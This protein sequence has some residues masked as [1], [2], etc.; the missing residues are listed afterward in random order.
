MSLIRTLERAMRPLKNRVMLMISR[1]VIE[2]VDD[3]MKMQL[4]KLSILKGETKDGVERMQNFG[5][6]SNPPAG[7]E[8]LV[9]FVAGNREHGVVVAADDRTK[10]IKDL[11]EGESVFFNAAGDKI[12]IKA[13]G[14]IE[15]IC[16]KDFLHT[17]GGELKA[18]ITGNLDLTFDKLKLQGSSDELVDLLVQMNAALKVEPM[19]VNKATFGIIE[20]KLTAMK[21]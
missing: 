19:I 11:A 7:S 17:I 14:T 18:T 20:T 12:H 10:R 21:V 3:S 1:A 13:D 5:F 16:S 6:S 15:L 8:A 2:S 4:V 9:V